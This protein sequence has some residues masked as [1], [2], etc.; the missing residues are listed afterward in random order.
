[1]KKVVRVAKLQFPGNGAKPG[2]ALA[3]IG[4][5]IMD[6]CNQ[7]NKATINQ[8]NEIVPVVITVYDDKTFTFVLKTTPTAVLIKKY[9]QVNKGAQKSGKETVGKLTMEQV[10]E[11]AK[12]KLPDLNTEDINQGVKIILG[13]MKQM[14]IELVEST[15]TSAKSN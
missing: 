8:K 3:S 2:P 14:G 7:F 11:I 12:Y 4:V 10:I 5:N 1:M 13:T 9:A 6:F 15:T